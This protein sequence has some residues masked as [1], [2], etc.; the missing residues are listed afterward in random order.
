M[1]RLCHFFVQFCR[2]TEN[3]EVYFMDE[4]ID[5]VCKPYESTEFGQR[6]SYI[7]IRLL[8]PKY[9]TNLK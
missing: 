2:N 8:C 4:A 1:K 6:S 5:F 7:P 3:G 9:D